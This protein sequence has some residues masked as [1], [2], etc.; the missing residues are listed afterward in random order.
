[1]INHQVKVFCIKSMVVQGS[2]RQQTVLALLTRE[3]SKVEENGGHMHTSI[4]RL[5]YGNGTV[6]MPHPLTA[7]VKEVREPFLPF[8]IFFL[9]F[10]RLCSVDGCEWVLH[11]WGHKHSWEE[12]QG[13]GSG[14]CMKHMHEMGEWHM[15]GRGGARA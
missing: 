2:S 1:M 11:I 10:H 13:G 6:L 3:S 5:L 7:G 9:Q 12:T 14:M 8:Q 15:H 4:D